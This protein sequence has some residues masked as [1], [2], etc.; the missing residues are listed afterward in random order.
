[1]VSFRGRTTSPATTSPVS[2]GAS[3]ASVGASVA[4]VGSSVGSAGAAVVSAGASVVAVPPHA[5]STRA[6]TSNMDK[7][8]ILRFIFLLLNFR[9]K[10]LH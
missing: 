1:M 10:Q 2:S 9:N 3:V 6:S 7:I 4:S 8:V 5:L